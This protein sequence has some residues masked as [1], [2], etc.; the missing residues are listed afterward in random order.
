MDLGRADLMIRSG[1]W[2]AVLKNRW[3]PVISA[4][5]IRFRR[6]LRA[7]QAFTLDTRIVTWSETSVVIEH[8][9]VS[10]ARGGGDV[11]NAVALVRAGLY[12]R[13]ARRFVTIERLF[14]EIGPSVAAPEFTTEVAAFLKAEDAL[15]QAAGPV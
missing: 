10:R 3:T 13:K 5:T 2:R 7:F 9:I 6:E 4:G 1:L 8:R 14:E 12:D 15:K 11:V